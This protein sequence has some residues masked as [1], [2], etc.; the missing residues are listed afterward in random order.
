M[1][2]KRE[3]DRFAG[4]GYTL[5]CLELARSVHAIIQ[6]RVRS[7]MA[8]LKTAIPLVLKALWL[9]AQDRC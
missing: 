2:V 4:V 9:S 3:W 6:M 8:V 7:L 5:T 1:T